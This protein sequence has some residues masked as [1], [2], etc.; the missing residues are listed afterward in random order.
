MDSES[1]QNKSCK[2]II[3]LINWLETVSLLR[4]RFRQ[5]ERRF[6]KAVWEAGKGVAAGGNFSK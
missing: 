6:L 2:H 3:Y 5:L 1:G 4:H